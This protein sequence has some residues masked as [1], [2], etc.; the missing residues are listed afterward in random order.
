MQSEGRERGVYL[1]VVLEEIVVDALV[2]DGDWV[3]TLGI[4]PVPVGVVI[5]IFH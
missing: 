2:V 1:G 5:E 3:V 4:L